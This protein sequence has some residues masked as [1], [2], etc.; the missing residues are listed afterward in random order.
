MV[1]STFDSADTAEGKLSPWEV[2]TAFAFHIVLQQAAD[3][4]GVPAH[5][6]LGKPVAVFIAENVVIKGGGHPTDRTIRQVIARCREP[7]WYPG[8]PTGARHGAGRKPVYTEHQRNEVARVAMDLK[9]KRIAPTPHRVRA[10]LPEAIRNPE[11]GERMSDWTMHETFRALCY[12]EDEDDTWQYLP[13]ASQDTL[14]SELMPKRV[15]CCKFILRTTTVRAWYSHIGIDPC[16]SLLPKTLERMEE[17]QLAAMGKQRWM[18]KG[19]RRHVLN[20]RAPATANHQG[21]WAVTRVDWTPIFARGCL[22]IYVVDADEAERDAA[23]PIKL[24]DAANLAK[25]VKTVLPRELEQMKATYGWP[26]LPRV[27]V[28]DKA[29][30]MVTAQHARLHITFAATL[31]EGGFTSWAGE[32]VDSTKWLVK[33]LGDLLRSGSA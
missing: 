9:R 30:Y 27:V 3:T 8:K 14:G 15:D 25:F 13:C 26:D 10:R 12:D 6:M 23:L 4:L 17:Q 19:S 20:L 28:H 16:Y 29:S 33:K 18:S 24:S 2:A 7:S 22:R 31:A 32:G 11:T 1:A 5:Q 21:G